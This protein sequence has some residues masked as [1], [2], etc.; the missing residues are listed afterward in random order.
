MGLLPFKSGG[1]HLAMRAGV[2]ILPISV[3]GSRHI[4]PKRSLR[5]E[6][7]RIR[8]CYGTPIPTQG[9]P[10][11]EREALKER[12]RAAI[13]AGLDPALQADP[14]P[15]EAGGAPGTDGSNAPHARE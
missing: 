8:I 2:P 13:E 10:L 9:V 14:D 4:T 1:F 12:V 3:S 15:T 5:I 6:S 7:G 11:E